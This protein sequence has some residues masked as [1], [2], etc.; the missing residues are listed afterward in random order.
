VF[1]ALKDRSYFEGR[2]LSAYN[3]CKPDVESL[4]AN[5]ASQTLHV[6]GKL[7]SGHAWPDLPGFM[8]EFLHLLRQPSNK[9]LSSSSLS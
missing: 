8:R 7:V 6:D 2:T 5:Y 9:E 1:L 4:G 3:A